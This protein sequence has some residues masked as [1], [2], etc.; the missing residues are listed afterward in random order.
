MRTNPPRMY[1]IVLSHGVLVV[2]RLATGEGGAL[3]FAV[4]GCDPPGELGYKD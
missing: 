3:R 1:A 4:Y 2:D